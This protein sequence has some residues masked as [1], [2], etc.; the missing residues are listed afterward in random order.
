MSTHRKPT[1]D[2]VKRINQSLE[3]MERAMDQ[4][5]AATAATGT[6]AAAQTTAAPAAT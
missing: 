5:P 1:A 4:K 3:A 2:E 6:P